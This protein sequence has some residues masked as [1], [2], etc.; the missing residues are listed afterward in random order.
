[1]LLSKGKREQEPGRVLGSYSS[2]H[3][4][5]IQV[6]VIQELITSQILQHPVIQSSKPFPLQ[7]DPGLH[8]GISPR[9][10]NFKHPCCTL[11]YRTHRSNFWG[12]TTNIKMLCSWMLAKL[13]N[14]L[15]F[16]VCFFFL[17]ARKQFPDGK[18]GGKV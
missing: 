10:S 2:E 9:Y 11:R 4:R 16:F 8:H 15:E 12:E 3:N 7:F 18:H 13:H 17:L 6:D 5:S 14:S 1:M